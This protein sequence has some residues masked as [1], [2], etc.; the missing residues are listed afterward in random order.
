MESTYIKLKRTSPHDISLENNDEL[1]IA[2]EDNV[3]STRD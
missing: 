2:Q 1:L 3:D